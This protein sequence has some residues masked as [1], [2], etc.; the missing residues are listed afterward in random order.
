VESKEAWVDSLFQLAGEI[1]LSNAE[2]IG[3]ELT[4]HARRCDGEVPIDCS[5]LAFID[6]SGL[7]MLIGVQRNT[8]KRLVLKALRPLARRTFELTNLDEV[9][10]IE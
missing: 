6:S 3:K 2:A 9:F 5:E 10:R 1:D 4:A 7:H 8:G